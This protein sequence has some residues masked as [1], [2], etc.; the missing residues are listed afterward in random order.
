M[1][2]SKNILTGGKISFGLNMFDRQSLSYNK[3]GIYKASIYRNDSL[4]FEYSFNKLDFEDSRF[5]NLLRHYRTK[6]EK[7]I[8]IQ[9]IIKHPESKKSFIT[10]KDNNGFFNIKN[11][12]KYFFTLKV[13]D[14]KGNNSFLVATYK[15][16][17][18]YNCCIL[19]SIYITL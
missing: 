10:N 12:E 9:R 5:I 3:N 2:K 14:Y 8:T 6:K 11:D 13:S 18:G 1:Y 17:S 7:G 16:Y 4:K 19:C 15:L